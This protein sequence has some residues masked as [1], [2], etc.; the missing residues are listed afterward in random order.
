VAPL[1]DTIEAL[2]WEDESTTLDFK[3]MQYPF[4]A[5]TDDQKGEIIKDILAFANTPRD[6]DAHII[7]GAKERKGHRATV[8][9]VTHHLDDAHLQQ[10]I[11]TKTN[12]PI[13]F[14]YRTATIDGKQLGI[15][16]IPVHKRF[17]Y[18]K[19]DFGKLR[20]NILYLRQGSSTSEASPEEIAHMRADQHNAAGY[21]PEIAALT[22]LQRH[23]PFY[24]RIITLSLN[25]SRIPSH[26][27]NPRSEEYEQERRK[28]HVRFDEEHD[29]FRQA[30]SSARDLLTERARVAPLE[31]AAITKILAA[32]REVE[33]TVNTLASWAN[34][35]LDNELPRDKQREAAQ[36]AEKLST[37]VARRLVTLGAT[38]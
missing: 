26:Y 16:Q 18:L 17:L 28:L 8:I 10:L 34:S 7:I 37:L 4:A 38:P 3:Q 15:I 9:G 29:A 12:R 36:A 32:L 1:D 13:T 24:Q 25:I 23:A 35:R 33:Q 5:A 22:N 31:S 21:S 11:N 14:T 19:K 2:L 6:R 27:E 30:M 20:S